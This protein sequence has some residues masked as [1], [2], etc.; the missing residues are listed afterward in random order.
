VL[1]LAFPAGN[2]LQEIVDK[3]LPYFSAALGHSGP[4]VPVPGKPT[5]PFEIPNSWGFGH[6]D[7]IAV[8][9]PLVPPLPMPQNLPPIGTGVVAQPAGWKPSWTAAFVSSRFESVPVAES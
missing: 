8:D 9:P 6:H 5:G 3:S 2:V 7:Y 1:S 4:R